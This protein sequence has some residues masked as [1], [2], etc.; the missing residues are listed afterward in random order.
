MMAEGLSNADVARQ[1][2]DALAPLGVVP[3]SKE[4]PEEPSVG[5]LR[6]YRRS[7]LDD[8]IG[9]L[10]LID[11]DGVLIWED[12]AISPTI[13]G[14]RR[15]RG[16][17]ASDGK[18]VTQLKYSKALGWNDIGEK[19]RQLDHQLTPNGPVE[20]IEYN[21]DSW[22]PQVR[23]T[24]IKQGRVLLFIHGT[25]SSC[26]NLMNELRG[27]DTTPF[28]GRRFL[29]KAAAHYDQV[30]GFDHHT[31]SRTPIV[32]AVELARKFADSDAELDIVCHSR[33]GLVSRWLCEQFDKP[34]RRRRVV[35]VGCP[36]RGTS[37]ADPQSLRN[38]L[39]L[40]TN[41]GKLLGTSFSL[42]PLLAAAGGLMQ[43]LSSVGAF[44]AKTPAVDAGIGLVPGLAAMSRIF[45][46]A[47]LDALNSGPPLA[48]PG[49]FAVVGNF[50]TEAAG[51]RFWKLFNKLKLAEIA[52][53]H[54]VFEQ[55]NDLVVDTESMTYH[56]FGEEPEVYHNDELFC[57]FNETRQ[58]HHT[59]YFRESDTVEFLTRSFRL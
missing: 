19:L 23:A 3:M 13:A 40:L 38:G 45:N 52:A 6:R 50:Q 9:I 34:G 14:A 5:Q 26:G 31:L 46:N 36:F 59:A 27:T 30:L 35:F 16:G 1:I 7:R 51:W 11:V 18:V 15:R 20:L 55:D 41:L 37:L 56:V 33:G 47:E 44:A 58:V 22:T 10:T 2:E 54:L 12:G 21:R 29:E 42:I 53:D 25:F 48:R 32:N 8:T 49:Y 39:T 24:P 4:L 17:L 28:P 43:I 57:Y